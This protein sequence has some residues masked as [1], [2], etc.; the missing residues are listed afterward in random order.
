[1]PFSRDAFVDL[2]AGFRAENYRFRS[3]GDPVEPRTIVMRHDIDFSVPYALELAR[4]E[5][6][7]GLSATYFFMATSNTYNVFSKANRDA[8]RAIRDLG[9]TTSLH[10][11]PTAYEDVGAGFDEERRAIEPITGPVEIVSIHRPGDFLTTGRKLSVPHTYEPE[12]FTALKYVSDSGGAFH[13]GHPLA[14]S[15][16]QE[17]RPMHLLVHP[18]WWVAEGE[19]PSETLRTWQADHFN[20]LNAEVGRNC[21]TF[22]GRCVLTAPYEAA[23]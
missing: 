6:E 18:V 20:F 1:M 13:H 3:F 21:K 14:D 17:G 16:V 5:A 23:A 2:V 4:I 19:T 7:L 15:A 10:F 11:D 9:H 8:V 12:Y 22:D